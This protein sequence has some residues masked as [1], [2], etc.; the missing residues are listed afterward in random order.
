MSVKL[1]ALLH[2]AWTAL[3]GAG[4]VVLMAD[5]KLSTVVGTGILAGLGGIWSGVGGVFTLSGSKSAAAGSAAPTK[6]AGAPS[7]PVPPTSV[8]VLRTAPDYWPTPPV[9]GVP[10]AA[11]AG[12]GP[13]HGAPPA[14]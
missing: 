14:S 1:A 10:F 9:A 7:T 5:H 13:E 12:L 3:V 8:T 2:G 11:G 6:E 4:V